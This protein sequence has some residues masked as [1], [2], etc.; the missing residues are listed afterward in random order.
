MIKNKDIEY[1][2]YGDISFIGN[3]ISFLNEEIDYI[4]QNSIDR[5]ITNFNDYYL[6]KDFGANI[7][8]FI[9]TTV[10]PLLEEK[11]VK[12]II[13]SLTIDNFLSREQISIAT[14]EDND[15]ILVKIEIGTG[16]FSIN[17]NITINSIFNTS[18]GLFYVT[19]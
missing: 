5:I 12:S 17:E 7:S 8:S 2:R 16:L 10:S 18:S 1:D 19:N 15:S 9:G 6:Y 13:R 14:L 11:I 4:Y 3:D